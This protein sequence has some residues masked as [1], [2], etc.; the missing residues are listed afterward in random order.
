MTDTITLPRSVVEQAL[1]TL[2]MYEPSVVKF[3]LT[4]KHGQ[5]AIAAISAALDQQPVSIPDDLPPGFVPLQREKG[6]IVYAACLDGGRFNGWLMWKHP[7]GQ[8]VS[9]RKLEDWEIMQAEDQRDYGIV[10][11]D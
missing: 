3:G 5:D 9:K 10:Q 1:A 4:F 6:R 11:G 8:W 2:R 7:D